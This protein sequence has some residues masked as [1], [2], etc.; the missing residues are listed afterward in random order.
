MKI[1]QNN[2]HGNN[3]ANVNGKDVELFQTK[4]KLDETLDNGWEDRFD[5]HIEHLKIPKIYVQSIKQFINN[6]LAEQ[7]AEIIERVENAPI[8]KAHTYASENADIYRAYDA[9]QERM[10]KDVLNIIKE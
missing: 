4:S 2:T 1:N 6:L 8:H 5:F 7:K 10:K 3:Y 9:G